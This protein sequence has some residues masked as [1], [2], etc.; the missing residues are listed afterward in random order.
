MNELKK[1]FLLTIPFKG[2]RVQETTPQ[3]E[4][5]ITTRGHDTSRNQ[6]LMRTARTPSQ[7]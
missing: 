1:P 6:S 3:K 7:L 4:R 5:K 2:E